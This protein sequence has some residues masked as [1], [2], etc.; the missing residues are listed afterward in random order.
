MR[1][2]DCSSDVCSSDLV[3]SNVGDVDVFRSDDKTRF[4][5]T[6]SYNYEVR[7]QG[8]RKLTSY[9]IHFRGELKQGTLGVGVI[10]GSHNKNFW[11]YVPQNHSTS[12]RSKERRVGK[13]IFIKCRIRWYQ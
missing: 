13:A 5:H 1:M 10:T 6:Q 12:Q 11:M 8:G 9:D 7:D 4:R 2:S 3:A